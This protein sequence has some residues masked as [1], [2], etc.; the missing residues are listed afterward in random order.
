MERN[1]IVKLHIALKPTRFQIGLN[2]KSFKIIHLE[3][4]VI[5]LVHVANVFHLFITP[6][7]IIS[8]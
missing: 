2:L 5:F 1:L 6:K 7:K 4:C 3:E 8:L